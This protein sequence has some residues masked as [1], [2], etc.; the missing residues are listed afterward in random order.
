ML[1]LPPV[2]SSV[3]KASPLLWTAQKEKATTPHPQVSLFGFVV[4]FP[5]DVDFTFDVYRFYFLYL[6]VK[7]ELPESGIQG[8]S[9]LRCSNRAT[10]NRP[11]SIDTFKRKSIDTFKRLWATLDDGLA[12]TPAGGSAWG[13][14]TIESLWKIW[15]VIKTKSNI[16]ERE[17]FLDWG[18]GLGKMMIAA[19]LFS[20]CTNMTSLGI[21]K[22][23]H[24]YYKCKSNLDLFSQIHHRKCATVLSNSETFSTFSPATIIM[25]YDGPPPK[26]HQITECFVKIMTTIL[27]SSSVK[28][29][30]STKLNETTFRMIFDTATRSQW[31]FF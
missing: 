4:V 15:E 1:I 7:Q 19:H 13:Q 9:L 16:L 11:Q 14:A 2:D 17:T 31:D 30:F 20:G 5:V 6:G 22:D 27:N 25:Q 28:V 3:E 12:V 23:K 26:S 21:E 18:A 10:Q 24:L 8:L 29:L